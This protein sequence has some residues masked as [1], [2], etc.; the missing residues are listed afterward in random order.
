MA[1]VGLQHPI[2]PPTAPGG[3]PCGGGAV[4][5]AG[6]CPGARQMC[7]RTVRFGF[8]VP[9]CGGPPHNPF[10]NQDGCVPVRGSHAQEKREVGG[11]GTVGRGGH[12]LFSCR[13]LTL[14]VITPSSPSSQVNLSRCCRWSDSQYPPETPEELCRQEDGPGPARVS[15]LPRSGVSWERGPSLGVGGGA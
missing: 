1:A 13:L 12:L 4:G 11:E 9:G 8:F 2:P 5:T 7:G 3:G 10:H 15:P 6:A 14:G